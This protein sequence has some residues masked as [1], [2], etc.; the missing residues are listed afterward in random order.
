[1]CLLYL[2]NQNLTCYIKSNQLIIKEDEK[3]LEKIPIE[4]IE[5][6]VIRDYWRVSSKTII[7][8][9]VR[10]I[11]MTF[12]DKS[13]KYLGSF[14]NE[15]INIQ[16]QR[17]Q[18]LRKDDEKFCLDF[19]KK[20]IQSKVNNQILIL[21]R[22]NSGDLEIIKNNICDMKIFKDKIEKA[23][24]ISELNGY[25]GNV[26]KIYFESLSNLVSVEF[27][28]KG[29]SK[30][31]PK[32]EFN[33]LLSL[34][35][36]LLFNEIFIV[37]NNSGLN[38]YAG[39]MHQDKL[40]HAALISDL[41][42]EWRAIIVDSMILNL[43]SRNTISTSDFT[44]DLETGAFYLTHDAYKKFIISFNKKINRKSKYLKQI[45]APITFRTA[46]YYKVNQLSKAIENNDLNYYEYLKMR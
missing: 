37:V 27:R 18:F 1:M 15:N 28:F 22:Y 35:Y 44:K 12:V 29:R 33:T 31:P 40:G 30:R 17:N 6:M 21:R 3:E 7:Q 4:T 46:I 42:E 36:T 26:A 39:F 11:P 16:K 14:L 34:G 23:T 45:D 41:M 13:G 32:D 38:P 2:D 19:S 9:L 20:I 25:E 5:G 8:L 24:S 43:I 10:K